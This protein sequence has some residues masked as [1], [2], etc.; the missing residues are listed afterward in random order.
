MAL[1]CRFQV[2]I[3]SNSLVI[4]Q[5]MVREEQSGKRGVRTRGEVASPLMFLAKCISVV[6]L[7]QVIAS[8]DREGAQEEHRD[9]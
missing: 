7:T 2:M 3:N 5:E 9:T 4:R 1:S 8:H 6:P